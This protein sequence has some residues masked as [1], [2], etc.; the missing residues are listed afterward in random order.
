MTWKGMSTKVGFMRRVMAEFITLYESDI[1]QVIE[2]DSA[3]TIGRI[4]LRH[5]IRYGASLL[6]SSTTK[7][8]SPP[9][10]S[11]VCCPSGI[12]SGKDRA[13]SQITGALDCTASYLAR[14]RI[15][16]APKWPLII[17]ISGYEC[18]PDELG[19][20]LTI[21]GPGYFEGYFQH[22]NPGR[23]IADLFS[24]ADEGHRLAVRQGHVGPTRLFTLGSEEREGAMHL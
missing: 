9:P 11:Y 15:I 17:I 14:A 5:H 10:T 16:E 20:G 12:Y 22:D 3:I 8:D 1:L 23:L 18:P 6:T 13:S 2:Y 24:T 19:N 7:S 21:A 4:V